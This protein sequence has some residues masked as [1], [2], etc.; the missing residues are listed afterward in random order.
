MRQKKSGGRFSAA[1]K[2][3]AISLAFLVIGY[4]AALFIH[5]ASVEAIVARE[6]L[7][8][9]EDGRP[10]P[11]M[12]GEPQPAMTGES[13]PAMTREPQ[14]EAS[15]HSR[16]RPGISDGRSQP[17]MTD[18]RSAARASAVREEVARKYSQRSVESFPFDP[19]TASLEDLQRLGFSQKQAQSILNYRDAGGR[20]H[21]P[22]DFAKSF[23]VA[24]SVFRRLEP[25]I[26]IPRL[27]LN[28]A[29]STA[30]DQLPGIGPY[31]ASKMVE[32]REELRGYSFPEQLLDIWNFGQERLDGLRDL[33][34][35]GFSE[36]Y[37]LWTL[38][39]EELR[40]HPYIDR[41]AAH[42]IVLF[43][44]NSPEELCTVE[45]L[46]EAGILDPENGSKL[47]R[48]RIASP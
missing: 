28:A 40:E 6:V 13:Q 30:L 42:S 23:V 15:R 37:P 7:A 20:F 21:R 29:D 18:S 25:F 11:A 9:A 17:A 10:Q 36:P 43:R 3:G 4:Q 8:E 5:Q 27:D 48:C 39:E 16:P 38:P 45:N 22:S 26:R 35:V 2:T 32:Y 31:Y 24:D 41:H 14:P 1:F 33:I 44:D 19:N 34:E 47:A 46:V 12:T